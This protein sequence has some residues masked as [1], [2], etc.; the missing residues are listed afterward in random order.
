MD[1]VA[2]LCRTSSRGTSAT[3]TCG[4]GR[5]LC[6]LYILYN[7]RY[8]HVRLRTC[9]VPINSSARS[10]PLQPVRLRQS[11]QQWLQPRRSLAHDEICTGFREW[12]FVCSRPPALGCPQHRRGAVIVAAYATRRP[13]TM[14]RTLCCPPHVATLQLRAP[15]AVQH[16]ATVDRS[17]SRGNAGSPRPSRSSAATARST[18]HS[19][20]TSCSCLRTSCG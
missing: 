9:V 14:R 15:R 12:C 6:L 18:R 11:A 1:A 5:T 8:N 3:T 20:A 17:V 13:H 16:G 10:R 7:F 2:F 4:C 19:R